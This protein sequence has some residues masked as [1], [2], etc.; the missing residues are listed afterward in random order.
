MKKIYVKIKYNIIILCFFRKLK[1]KTNNI[2]VMET[3]LLRKKSN[4]KIYKKYIY[5][6]IIIIYIFI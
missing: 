6:E 1:N 2:K 4:I 5:V 3:K